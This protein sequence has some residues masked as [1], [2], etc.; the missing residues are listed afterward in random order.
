[1]HYSEHFQLQSSR[2]GQLLGHENFYSR[3]V[4]ARN[5][6]VW[7]PPGY[8][9][10]AEA[11]YP[12]IY[13]HDGQNLFDPAL[14]FAGVD[15][16]VDETLGAMILAQSVPPAI[17][18]G[19]WNTAERYREY[20]PQ[21]VFADL[22]SAEEQA[23]Y[24][25]EFGH[26]LADRYLRFI[27]EELKPVIDDYFCTRRERQSTFMMGSSMGGL[28]STYALCEYPQT[29]GAVAALSTHWPAGCGKMIDYLAT[30]LP[31]PGKH[32]FYFDYGTETDDAPYEPLQRQVDMLLEEYG[33]QEGRDRMTR[34]F[35]GEDH[36]EQ[37]W[38]R[39]LNVPLHF[40]LGE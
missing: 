25:L 29:F 27:V 1:M 35:P 23:A 8:G 18:V 10:R 40:L 20:D 37:A 31:A 5:I 3:L 12:V 6:N 36:S 14:S 21:K 32:R 30:H 9:E 7:L 19:I 15:W 34:K 4:E 38:R 39:R 33:Y 26:P 17:V 11:R 13:A 28:I 2:C 24:G 16:G 22:L